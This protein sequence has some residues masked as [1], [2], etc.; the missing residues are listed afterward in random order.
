[1]QLK[2]NWNYPTS[3]R[4]G[5][6][7]IRELPD[8]CRSLGMSRPLLVTD[9]G[10][11]KLPMVADVIKLC[12]DAGMT[13]V[14]YSSI[15]AN[16]VGDNVMFGVAT[17][18][19]GGHDGVIAFGGGSALD[20]GKAVGLMVGQARPLFDFEDREDWFMR[21]NVAGMAPVLAVP[22]TAGTGSEV[23]RASVITDTSDHIK[24]I[25]F[26]PRMLPGAVIEDPELT[27]GLPANITAATGMDALSH[28]LEAFCSPFY[29]P[30]AEGVA[31]EGMRLVKEWL[32]AAVENGR[33]IEA[34]SH[35]LIASSMGATAF[36]KGLGA[37]HSLSHPCGANLN[38]HH[39][40]T[41]AVVMPY[42]LMW[43]RAVLGEK[44]Q[45]LAAYLGLPGN[46][47]EAVLKWV[48]ELRQR[49]GIPNTLAEIGVRE[50][51]AREFA[52]QALADPS[53][54]GNPVPMS[55]KDFEQLYLNCIRGDLR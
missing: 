38:T 13:C 37:M 1:V 44:M 12:S 21:V 33:N 2:G 54:S 40:L 45:R 53:T 3:I 19:A 20:V 39:G 32:P 14:A 8:V 49:I 22:T 4:F 25:I 55:E 51:H 27:V 16:P 30:M 29:H 42:V 10:L 5:A 50:E 36:Q 28:S 26:H 7:R 35:M 47:F 31:V 9:P 15:Q 48:L 43:N 11:A 18:Q 23:G 24:K 41:N 6:G 34:R 46:G 52:G 17:Y